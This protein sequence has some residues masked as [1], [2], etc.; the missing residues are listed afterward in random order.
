MKS[1]QV[2]RQHFSYKILSTK[3]FHNWTTESKWAVDNKLKVACGQNGYFKKSFDL[4]MCL[5]TIKEE[6]FLYTKS[7]LDYRNYENSE[8]FSYIIINISSISKIPK[9][10]SFSGFAMEV[11]WIQM[12]FQT[13][14]FLY[15]GS[16]FV[17]RQKQLFCILGGK[18]SPFDETYRWASEKLEEQARFVNRRRRWYVHS[19]QEYVSAVTWQ[20]KNFR[21]EQSSL[22]A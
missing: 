20:T 22:V 3:C 10:M 6:N 12:S 1:R 19:R 13:V 8:Q 17:A 11:T 7:S 5:I 21:M 14:H 2:W 4:K 16:F 18:Y 9:N 15:A